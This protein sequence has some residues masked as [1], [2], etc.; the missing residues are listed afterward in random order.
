M[1]SKDRIE[2]PVLVVGAGPS[3]LCASILLSLHGV[4]S[5]TV[6]RHPGTSIYPR[7]T[8]INIRSMEIFRSMGVA[9]QVH[10]VSF[11]AEPR[12]AFSRVLTDAEPGVSPS[13]RTPGLDVSPEEWTSCSQKELEPILLRAATSHQQAQLLFGTE[14]LGFEET[15]DGITAHIWDRASGQPREVGCK[16]L[17]AADGSKSRVRERLGLKMLGVGLLGHNVSIHFSA[18]LRRHLPSTPNFLHFVQNG[19][20]AGMFIATDTGSRWVFAVPY[21]PNQG[22]STDSFTHERAV[23]L[24]RKGAG[25]PGLKVEV[26]GIVPWRT[27]ADSVERW[28]VG[29]VFLAGDAAHRMTPA[30][31]LGLNTGIQD[32]HNLCWKLAAVIKGWAGP[33]LLDT[34]EAE[35][36]PVAEYNVDRSVGIITGDDSVNRRTGLDVDLGFMYMSPAIVPDGTEL[37]HVGGGDY[38]PVARPG[39]R[40]PHLWLRGQQGRLSMLDLFGPHFT[41]LTGRCA[42]DWRIAARDIGNEFRAPLVDRATACGSAHRGHRDAWMAAYGVE[43]TGAVLIRPDGHV[44]WRRAAAPFEATELRRALTAA[45]GRCADPATPN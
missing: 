31:G 4:E 12:I 40:A 16:Y 39:S 35:R 45:V 24:V 37:P 18:P 6:E 2:V 41:L 29:N 32:V 26:M 5:L 20:V 30:G 17:I 13:F 19:D 10:S 8:G 33:A 44:A 7:A 28:R 27:E 9:D 3:G 1:T 14:L 38:R 21:Q 11:K 25:L 23:E 43:E 34:Y 15:S 36:R 42:E 22:Q